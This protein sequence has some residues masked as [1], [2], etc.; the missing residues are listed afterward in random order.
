MAILKLCYY[1]DL[2][3]RIPDGHIGILLFI[4]IGKLELCGGHFEVML[5]IE[6]AK[7]GLTGG[8]IGT[9]LFIEIK[10]LE[11]PAAILKLYYL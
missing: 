11:F 8:H 9:L 2:N 5:F 1:R 4:E 10:N 7:I 6:I 3:N